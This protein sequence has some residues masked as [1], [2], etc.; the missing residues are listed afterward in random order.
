[1]A[2]GQ[3]LVIRIMSDG[4]EE[5]VFAT[6][7]TF[8]FDTG[9]ES[10][11]SDYLG[12]AAPRVAGINRECSIEFPFD[13]E[14][15]EYLALAYAQRQ[16]NVGASDVTISATFAVDFGDEGENR[17]LMSDCTLHSANLS[18]GGRTEKLEGSPTLTAPTWEPLV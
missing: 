13:V 4:V 8:E 1:M 6:S 16:K 14:G 9:L 17:I 10:E 18:S 15:P 12:E 11:I 5:S 2:R 7:K 3:D